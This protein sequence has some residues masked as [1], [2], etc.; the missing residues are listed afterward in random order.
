MRLNIHRAHKKSIEDISH[1]DA[2]L[3]VVHTLC[4]KWAVLYMMMN[5]VDDQ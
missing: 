2:T 5:E 3:A 4:A 1:Q